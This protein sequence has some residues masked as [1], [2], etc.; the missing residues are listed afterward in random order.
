M[1][2]FVVALIGLP[3]AGKSTVA[4]ALQQRFDLH[5]VNRDDIRASMF[6]RCEF[7]PAEKRAAE[8][9]VMEALAVNR[10]AGRSC[11]VDGMTFADAS[12]LER[13][14]TACDG[15]GYR[16]LPLFLDCPATVAARRVREAQHVAADRNAAL[17]AEVAQR[18]DPP[19]DDAVRLDATQPVSTVCQAATAAIETAG[20]T[21][22]G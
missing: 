2:R 12:V 8:A 19:P 20:E 22:L 6:P 9:A 17:V 10:Q 11:I 4:R 13:L 21:A 14:R 15:D 3:G 16:L 18:F 7:T 1:D 5:I